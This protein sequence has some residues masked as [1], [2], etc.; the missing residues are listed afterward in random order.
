[1]LQYLKERFK[2]YIAMSFE[3]ENKS[4][5][6]TLKEIF[7]PQSKSTSEKP[8]I[9]YDIYYGGSS[10]LVDSFSISAQELET[11]F[12]KTLITSIAD[13]LDISIFGIKSVAGDLDTIICDITYSGKHNEYIRHEIK[14]AK[15]LAIDFDPDDY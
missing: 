10:I 14:R 3:L 7:E 15:S 11:N 9:E 6:H 5:E 2:D 1:M 8:R 13:A 4:I 12:K